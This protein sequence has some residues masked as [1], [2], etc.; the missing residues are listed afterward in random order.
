MKGP[1]T[2]DT[3]SCPD[4]ALVVAHWPGEDKKMCA[5]CATRARNVGAAMGFAVSLSPY[6]PKPITE[7]T[8][9]T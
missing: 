3:N 7:E 2:C 4:D 8:E 9:A 6:L 5:P 1:N